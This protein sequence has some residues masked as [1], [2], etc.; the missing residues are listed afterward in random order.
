MTHTP[1]MPKLPE[2][3]LQRL[4]S[5]YED[6][7]CENHCEISKRTLAECIEALSQRGEAVATTWAVYD[8]QGF[9]ELHLCED[10]ASKWCEK[11]NAR[12]NDP[13]KPYTYRKCFVFDAA[14]QP[15]QPDVLSLLLSDEVLE[16]AT[17]AHEQSSCHDLIGP[18]SDALKAA[19]E[20]VRA[21]VPARPAKPVPVPALDWQKIAENLESALERLVDL[22]TNTPGVVGLSDEVI[23]AEAALERLHKLRTAP[24]L[25]QGA[26]CGST[27]GL[28]HSAECIIETANVQGW[29]PTRED[30]SP[31]HAVESFHHIKEQP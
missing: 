15:A 13:L 3:L 24:T 30:F 23:F 9:Y 1:P 11:Y 22:C 7:M 2:P 4:Q 16:A 29:T 14:P 17:L 25:C 31:D 10:S 18:M 28:T 6:P 20:C 27:D 26:N 19:A 12:A 8:S 21:M 5:I